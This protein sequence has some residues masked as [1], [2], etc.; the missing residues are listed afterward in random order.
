MTRSH[1]KLI[2]DTQLKFPREKR[3]N[4]FPL[5]RC[6][7]FSKVK[8]R[9]KNLK[10][11]YY[12]MQAIANAW[13]RSLSATAISLRYR[14]IFSDFS[15]LLIQPLTH[16]KRPRIQLLNETINCYNFMILWFL[17]DSRQSSLRWISQSLISLIEHV[18]HQQNSE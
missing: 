11:R 18:I 5:T 8:L 9:K 14:G 4:Q 3:R 10:V 17:I 2:S 7:S 13:F 15:I 12:Y 16:S 6:I 1:N